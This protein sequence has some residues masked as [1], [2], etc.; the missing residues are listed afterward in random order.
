[1]IPIKIEAT[2]PSNIGGYKNTPFNH[3]IELRKHDKPIRGSYKDWIKSE[4]T[5]SKRVF[6]EAIN[7]SYEELVGAAM[8][9]ILQHKDYSYIQYWIDNEVDDGATL[10]SNE[11]E[12]KLFIQDKLIPSAEQSYTASELES[13]SIDELIKLWKPQLVE[14]DRSLRVQYK[15]GVDN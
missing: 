8:S 3:P 10:A 15:G 12:L 2:N 14:L 7:L 4:L 13:T 11:N 9:A 6:L 5:E 1:M